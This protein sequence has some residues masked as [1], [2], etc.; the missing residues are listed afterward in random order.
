MPKNGTANCRN[1]PHGTRYPWREW[2]SQ[3]RVVLI[4]GRDFHCRSDTLVQMAY[5]R[6]RTM[7]PDR[8]ETLNVSISQ[9][10]MRVT[11]LQVEGKPRVKTAK[12]RK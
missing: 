5:Q 7:R 1:R 2:F 10:A 9:D 8:M 3:P 4:R 11:I 12:A 6:A